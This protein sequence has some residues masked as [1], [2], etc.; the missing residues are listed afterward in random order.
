V[1]EWMMD[2]SKYLSMTASPI[3]DPQGEMV[4]AVQTVHDLTEVAISQERYRTVVDSAN[5]PIMLINSKCGIV[6][7][8]DRVADVFGLPMEDVIGADFSVL[9]DPSVAGVVMQALTQAM[10]GGKTLRNLEFKSRRK[11]GSTFFAELSAGCI[12]HGGTVNGMQITI[13]DVTE[14]KRAEELVRMQLK[15]LRELDEMKDDFVSITAH[16]MKTPLISIL[17]VPDIMLDDKNL[18]PEQRDGLSVVLADGRKLKTIIERILT[19]SRLKAGKIAYDFAPCSVL[20]MVSDQRFTFERRFKEKSIAFEMKVDEG[21]P[22][23]RADAN[24]FGE[25]VA[26][27]LDNALKFTKGGGRIEVGARLE[28]ESVLVWVRDDGIGM[29][30]EHLGKIFE[31][32]YQVE[33][34]DDRNY[35]GTGLGLHICKEIIGAHGG[36]IWAES[37][38]GKGTAFYFTIPISRRE[39]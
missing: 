27:L 19:E 5:D 24:L 26:N 1:Q 30:P 21:L 20:D 28:G 39:D 37:Q 13:R 38:P 31:K 6:F 15:E 16:E 8:N 12:D 7:S 32:F 36:R 35:G 33:H 25:V 18:T 9:V 29:K 23:V 11:D 3:Y 22:K 14:R 10:A 34:R 4:A 2:G 17:N